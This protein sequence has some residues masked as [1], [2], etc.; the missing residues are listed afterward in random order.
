VASPHPI[1]ADVRV[2]QAIRMA[3]DV[4]TI[5]Q[6]IFYGY[7]TPVWTELFRPPYVCDIP[8][9]KYDSEAAAA[10]LESAG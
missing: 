10:L 7:G 1:L 6:Q 5:S 4:D 2:R 9:P 8:R 3:I